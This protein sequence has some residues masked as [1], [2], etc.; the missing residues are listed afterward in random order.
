MAP[1][2]S[3]PGCESCFSLSERIAELEKRISTLYKIQKAERHLDTIIFS[4]VQANATSTEDLATTAHYSGGAGTSPAGPATSLSA[5]STPPA[6]VPA[7][8]ADSFPASVTFPEDPWLRLGAK[9]KAPVSSTPAHPEPHLQPW[10]V[11]TK[12]GANLPLPPRMASS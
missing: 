4:P 3:P 6:E 11:V 5:A 2:T 9:P 7:P 1:L 12:R 10:S 8:A